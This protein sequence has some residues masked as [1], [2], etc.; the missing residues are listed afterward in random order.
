MMCLSTYMQCSCMLWLLH[1]HC[2]SH[3]PKDASVGKSSIIAFLQNGYTTDMVKQGATVMTT[4][5]MHHMYSS[6]L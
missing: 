5:V 4:Y 1:P 3:A 6:K 2:I